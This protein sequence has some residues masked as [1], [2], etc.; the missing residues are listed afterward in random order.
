MID[1]DTIWFIGFLKELA[2]K[3]EEG[4]IPFSKASKEDVAKIM[5]DDS[6]VLHE[7]PDVL[8]GAKEYPLVLESV[9]GEH[10]QVITSTENWGKTDISVSVIACEDQMDE[11]YIA[12]EFED[13]DW[14][15]FIQDGEWWIEGA[16]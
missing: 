7:Y 4:F 2:E 9:I 13:Q 6:Q 16:D 15:I 8:L 10:Q 14:I 5:Y 12:I 3:S 11:S 1:A